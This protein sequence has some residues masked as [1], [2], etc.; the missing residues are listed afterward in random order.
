MADRPDQSGETAFIQSYLAPL[1]DKVSGAFGLQDDAA[2]L[3]VGDD[4]DV[5]VTVDAIAAGTHFFE[6]DSAA[7]IGWKALAVNVSDLVAKG[8]EPFAYVMSLALPSRPSHDWMTSFCS[9]LG[10]AQAVF[11][12]ALAGGDTDVRDGPLAIT[13]TALGRV[14][15]GKVVRRSGGHPGDRLFLTGT[16]GDAAIGLALRRDDALCRQMKLSDQDI[17]FLLNRYH[18]PKVRTRIAP[19][20]QSLA[21]ASIDISDGL[22]KDA[23][24]LAVAS[25]CGLKVFC[26]TIP[27]SQ[28]ARIAVASGQF[29]GED[30]IT[31]GGDYEVL[32]AVPDSNA[33]K[34]ASA[35]ETAG[36]SVTEIGVLTE[37]SDVIFLDGEG[38]PLTFHQA[39]YDHFNA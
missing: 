3:D 7:D 29:S 24:S 37:Q 22:V 32:A 20:V 2:A 19:V 17:D 8:A 33:T 31:A 5:V 12:I 4:F 13:I 26:N 34:F 1:A 30:L 23:T 14:P 39:G 10:A 6:D 38:Q 27:I 18:R 15:K 25:S 9:G 21:S 36:V 28:S 16:I 11:K 35:A